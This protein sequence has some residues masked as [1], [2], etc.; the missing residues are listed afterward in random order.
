MIIIYKYNLRMI[1]YCNGSL[2]PWPETQGPSLSAFILDWA[3][4]R[5]HSLQEININLVESKTKQQLKKTSP[6]IFINTINPTAAAAPQRQQHIL[7]PSIS[8]PRCLIY[9]KLV[10]L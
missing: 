4:F 3:I 8:S 10:Q 9:K 5:N 7:C 6:S 2:L 1:N